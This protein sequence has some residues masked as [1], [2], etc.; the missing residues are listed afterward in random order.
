MY[1]Y[2]QRCEMFISETSLI[3]CLRARNLKY[4]VVSVAVLFIHLRPHGFVIIQLPLIVAYSGWST[5]LTMSVAGHVALIVI[6][7]NKGWLQVPLNI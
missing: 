4:C 6:F 3:I 2:I 1:V 7:G 5:I